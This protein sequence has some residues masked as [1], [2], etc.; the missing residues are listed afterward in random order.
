[1]RDKIKAAQKTVAHYDA[2]FFAMA[3]LDR[4]NQTR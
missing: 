2:T 3:E 4:A 1:M